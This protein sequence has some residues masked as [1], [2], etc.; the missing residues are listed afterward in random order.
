[1]K[2]I[3]LF[4]LV[5]ACALSACGDSN[6]NKLQ[7]DGVGAPASLDDG[8][9]LPPVVAETVESVDSFA[10]APT[11]LVEPEES[12]EAVETP[13]P[14]KAELDERFNIPVLSGSVVDSG[15]DVIVNAANKWL[16]AGGALSGAIYN[17]A[18]KQKLYDEIKAVKG[19]SADPVFGRG[20]VLLKDGEV[21]VT[22]GHN[23]TSTKKTQYILHAL[24]PD[25]RLYP[26]KENLGI[27]YEKLA[28]TYKTVYA[29]MHEL[30]AADA[31]IRSV[32][33]I[34]VSSG[35][36]AGSANKNKLYEVLVAESVAAVKQYP[37][38]QPKIY[39]FGG[40]TILT[41]IQGLL[42]VELDKIRRSALSSGSVLLGAKAMNVSPSASTSLTL[43]NGQSYQLA[44]YTLQ[45]G[46][47]LQQEF[48]VMQMYRR[49]NFSLGAEYAL[50]GNVFK[51][52]ALK[53]GCDIKLLKNLGVSFGVGSA[54]Q[55]TSFSLNPNVYKF[56]RQNG[57]AHKE[58]T[59]T[60]PIADIS[61][62]G[63]QPLLNKSNLQFRCGAR[64]FGVEHTAYKPFIS[65][66]L[67]SKQSCISV[68]CSADEYSFNFVLNN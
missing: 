9:S 55:D 50:Q 49:A 68:L 23:L 33:V 53:A 61:F 19:L 8:I 1:M 47:H 27:G 54:Y 58:F 12:V 51:W 59:Q 16:A 40:G 2:R 60:Q 3:D 66:S 30:A 46:N 28:E 57:F 45:C 44:E 15:C 32:G 56:F 52:A 35:V 62:Y 48:Q 22:K 31:T 37:D 41:T 65:A 17:A 63:T 14:V 43:L 20:P 26:Y 13:A 29:K 18:G 39:V 38:I 34:P 21:F 64:L 25:F 42:K 10:D 6:S 67:G 5:L 24:G 4:S 7:E 11:A 36:F